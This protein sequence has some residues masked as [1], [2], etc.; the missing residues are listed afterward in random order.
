MIGNPKLLLFYTSATSYLGLQTKAVN[1][2]GGFVS[3]S[4]VQFDSMHN[5]F[6]ELSMYNFSRVPNNTRCL[7]FQNMHDQP[8]KKI[9]IWCEFLNQYPVANILA[10]LSMPSNK[11]E[12]FFFEKIAR[13][14]DVPMYVRF[15]NI[16]GEQNELVV[17]LGENAINPS[18]Y[19]G[20]WLRRTPNKGVVIPCDS[21]ESEDNMKFHIKYEL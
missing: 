5:I 14:Y 18:G 2:L 10:G 15:K 1:S 3:S 20:L 8:I 9:S 11:G 4:M 6:G 13:Q 16:V 7:A 12:G 17:D 19:L 21:I